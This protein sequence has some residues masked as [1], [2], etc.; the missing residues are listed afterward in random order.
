MNFIL[1]LKNKAI[2]MKAKKKRICIPC[3]EIF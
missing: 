3:T 1:D 2:N